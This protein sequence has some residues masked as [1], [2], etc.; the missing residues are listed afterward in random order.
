MPPVK[1]TLEA[2]ADIQSTYRF[3][4]PKDREAATAAIKAI[5]VQ[6]R[7]LGR[8]PEAGRPAEGYGL[9]F[10]EWVIDFGE[11]GYVALYRFDTQKVVILAVRHQKE[12]G[13]STGEQAQSG[14][15]VGG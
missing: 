1:Y 14:E 7:I 11:S 9:E 5:R 4:A 6:L 15:P 13:Y 12:L 10:R 2:Q 3:L 8:H